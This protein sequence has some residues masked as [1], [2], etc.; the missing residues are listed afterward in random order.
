MS[1]AIGAR[2]LVFLGGA[3]HAEGNSGQSSVILRSIWDQPCGQ[4]TIHFCGMMWSNASRAAHCK[5]S[6][7]WAKEGGGRG[8]PWGRHMEGG[9]RGASW[10][11]EYGKSQEGGHVKTSPVRSQHTW[12]SGVGQDVRSWL[13]QCELFPNRLI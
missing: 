8:L 6:A 5:H 4:H 1:I 11:G 10:N 12:P 9:G 2:C 3:W 7:V 13:I